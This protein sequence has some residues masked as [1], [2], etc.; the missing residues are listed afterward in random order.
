MEQKIY[1]VANWKMHKTAQEAE[2][3][4]STLQAKIAD[5]SASVYLAVPFTAIARAFSAARHTEILI[6]A[7]NMSDAAQGAF[8]GEISAPMLKEAGASFVLLGHS[9]RRRLFGES[10]SFIH[11]KLV[12]ALEEGLQPILCIG[13][14]LEEREEG[15]TREVIEAQLTQAL[16]SIEKEKLSRMMVAYEPVWAIGTGKSATLE[17]IRQAHQFCRHCL[18]NGLGSKIGR[19]LP[20]LYGGSVKADNGRQIVE[21]QDVDGVLVG[22]ASLDP[23]G[24]AE[25]INQLTSP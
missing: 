3:Y 24:F 25:L 11:R 4:V 2:A 18:E 1:I 16:G 9:E 10:D 5:C 14:T 15:R 23:N 7:Q 13:E 20:I 19:S 6:G 22:G 17:Q 12:T 8:T 21:Q